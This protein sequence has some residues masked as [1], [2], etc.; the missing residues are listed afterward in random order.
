MRSMRESHTEPENHMHSHS[1]LKGNL[2][3]PI[4]PRDIFPA[5]GGPETSQR[6]VQARF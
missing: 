5:Q 1:L 2:E 4:N 3:S 6:K